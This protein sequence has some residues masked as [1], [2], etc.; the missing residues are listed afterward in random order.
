M[1]FLE[2]RARKSAQF[3]FV[4][5]MIPTTAEAF[6]KS[7]NLAAVKPQLGSKRSLELLLNAYVLGLDIAHDV[8][9]DGSSQAHV[10]PLVDDAHVGDGARTARTNVA[11][12]YEH[13]LAQHNAPD[14]MHIAGLRDHV[15]AQRPRRRAPANVHQAHKVAAEGVAEEVAGFLG[16]D[17]RVAHEALFHNLGLK[18]AEPLAIRLVHLQQALAHKR[19][20]GQLP[21]LRHHHK[22]P[23]SP[24]ESKRTAKQIRAPQTPHHRNRAETGQT[25]QTNQTGGKNANTRAAYAHQGQNPDT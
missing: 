3:T 20:H 11:R 8:H 9:G 15:L 12:L 5:N 17:D 1:F 18:V 19:F 7:Q 22:L 2:L 16:H 13:V 6:L 23:E 4:S 25:S 24:M 14:E 21:L 10:A